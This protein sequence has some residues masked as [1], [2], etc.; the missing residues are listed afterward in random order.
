MSRL[1]NHEDLRVYQ[2]SIDFVARRSLTRKATEGKVIL[3]DVGCLGAA[4]AA[5]DCCLEY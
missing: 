1:F 3:S 5:L 4:V 2:A